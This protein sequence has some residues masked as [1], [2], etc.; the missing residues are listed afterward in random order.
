[1]MNPPKF[2]LV[3]LYKR[4]LDTI[5]QAEQWSWPE[6]A[7]TRAKYYHEA[8][9]LLELLENITVFHVGL[10]ANPESRNRST[11]FNT[12]VASFEY[13]LNEKTTQTKT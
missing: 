2:T 10:G 5:K 3:F 13:L 6:V 7:D 4:I 12:R 9:A 11:Q 1:M 8:N